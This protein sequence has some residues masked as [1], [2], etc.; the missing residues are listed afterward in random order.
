MRN[1][2]HPFTSTILSHWY[3]GTEKEEEA[4]EMEAE[5]E[6]KGEGRDRE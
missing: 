1:T 6:I 4:M 5:E 2:N 3:Q